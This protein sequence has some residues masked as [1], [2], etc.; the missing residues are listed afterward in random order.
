MREQRTASRHARDPWQVGLYSDGAEWASPPGAGLDGLQGRDRRDDQQRGEDEGGRYP[1]VPGGTSGW[2]GRRTA[3]TRKTFR[4]LW[5][6][7]ATPARDA[8]GRHPDAGRWSTSAARWAPWRPA[9]S[10]TS[11][12]WTATRCPTSRAAGSG[13]DRHGDPGGKIFHNSLDSGPGSTCPPGRLRA[14]VE[15]KF[16]LSRD[17]SR[18]RRN[19]PIP[20]GCRVSFDPAAFR[21]LA[22]RQT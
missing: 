11:W 19:R 13:Q 14:S 20:V 21:A 17:R 18:R 10:P 12:W 15:R 22:A 3:A 6:S 2:P 8:A 7:S 5:T 4:T 1:G 16:E 9:S